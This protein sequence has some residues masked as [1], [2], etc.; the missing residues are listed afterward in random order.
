MQGGTRLH[1][2]AGVEKDMSEPRVRK[3][4]LL[5]CMACCTLLF[6]LSI[7][8]SP[9]AAFERLD[10]GAQM[11][12]VVLLPARGLAFFA[13]HDRN[14][15]WAVNFITGDT[16]AKVAV[17][18]RPIS[19]ALSDDGSVLA[20]VNSLSNSLTLISVPDMES[21]GTVDV[22]KGANDVAPLPGGRFAVTCSFSDS[23]FIVDAS[24]LI[25]TPDSFNIFSV[26]NKVAASKSYLAVA[27]RAPSAVSIF[28]HGES[29]ASATITL[30]TAASGLAAMG[31][32]RFVVATKSR[33]FLIDAATA[34]I[35]VEKEFAA[36]DLSVSGGDIYVLAGT[37]V[38]LLDE[39]L[40]ERAKFPLSVSGWSVAA[41][42][43]A[44]VVVSPKDKA[45]HRYGRTLAFVP[46][47]KPREVEAPPVPVVEPEPIAP[48]EPKEEPKPVEVT[49]PI[50]AA[51]KPE[52]AAPPEKPAEEEKPDDVKPSWDTLKEERLGE[53]KLDESRK[54]REALEAREDDS[55]VKQLKQTLVGGIEAG[56]WGPGFRIP[57][58][59]KEMV[60]ESADLIS[61]IP[62]DSD[63]PW[64]AEGNVKLRLDNTDMTLDEL[65]YDRAAGE[66]RGTGNVLFEQEFATFRAD[67]FYYKAGEGAGLPD[68]LMGAKKETD[69]A[70]DA[71][72]GEVKEQQKGTIDATN[73]HVVEP[74]REFTADGLTYDLATKS[75]Q[76]RNVQGRVGQY[77]FGA[78]IM[79]VS[80]TEG[81]ASHHAWVTTCDKEKPHYK[82]RVKR[83]VLRADDTVSVSSARLVL[84][85]VATPL[86]W[87]QWTMSAGK[88][89]QFRF[90]FDSGHRAEIGHFL[91]IG[92]QYFVTPHIA[93]GLRLIP[94]S[95]AGVGLGF[96]SD[97]DYTDLEDKPMFNA[98]GSLR[99]LY[100]TEDRGYL[101]YYHRQ[102]F[103]ENTVL[104]L[105]AE[106]WSDRE[107]YKDFYYGRYRDRLEPRTFAN[108]T[109]TRPNYIA[110]GTVKKTTHDFVGETERLPE[111]SFHLLERPLLWNLYGTFDAT[112]GYLEHEPFGE[113]SG[114]LTSVGRLSL[115][116]DLNE[117]FSVTPFA[118]AT[119]VGY[120]KS[121]D[122]DSSDTNLGA[123]LGVTLQ[124]RLHRQF[125]GHFG[126][127][128][129]KHVVVPSVTYS[130]SAEPS[131]ELDE[132]PYFDSHDSL[133]GRSR[134]ESKIDNLLFGRFGATQ[135]VWQVA[136]LTLYQGNDFSNGT[137][138]SQDFEVEF[139][140]R[141]RQWWGWQFISEHHRVEDNVRDFRSAWWIQ[142]GWLN[143][144]DRPWWWFGDSRFYRFFSSPSGDYDRMLTS[145]Y[146]DDT[147]RGGKFAGEIGLAYAKTEE[148]YV[149]R[150]LRYSA[151][152]HMSDKWG[153][154]FEH[155]YDFDR[156]NLYRQTYEVHRNLHCWDMISFVRKRSAGWDFGV[157]F[158]IKGLPGT[159]LKL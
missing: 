74:L 8:A 26:P 136:R 130:Y 104:L 99:T 51:K 46:V 58:M 24:K 59:S 42:G 48:A 152:Y 124:T 43:D 31:G 109:F 122:D 49:E 27:T 70:E 147:A 151:E 1:H 80:E 125:P 118:E 12:D 28:K 137:S 128:G 153:L 155:R 6:A 120:S 144:R 83:A 57:D 73:V 139:D 121:L 113:R 52:E 36:G 15:V 150:E 23:V 11:R 100:T 107:F 3:A 72:A 45:W 96:E 69:T 44:V 37:K 39:S 50:V 110:T 30:G 159:H 158:T 95:R 47:E 77:Y 92:Q 112:G 90:D 94:T 62:T 4:Y 146:Y 91:N 66:V 132:R 32:D 19:L 2:I 131:M 67:S 21:L 111:L 14:E 61:G 98:T 105:Q 63:E 126:F 68:L 78:E 5:R 75:G 60:W 53:A 16:V 145:F 134:I 135:E 115:D 54:R 133:V 7:A 88:R 17:G 141:P 140:L 102:E 82:L 129:F 40:T 127:S 154:G 38:L 81:V 76:I 35:I 86:Y 13:V 10:A 108:L 79:D 142:S 156:G 123:T 29:S 93:L 117:A 22:G 64:R 149:N 20:C 119:A 87:P 25:A 106:Q 18:S 65:I 143:R 97:Y 157:E 103:H 71:G 85:K 138:K 55:V 41:S 89:G 84:G 148:E 101:E 114:R 116:W 56:S 34:K 9:A 33:L